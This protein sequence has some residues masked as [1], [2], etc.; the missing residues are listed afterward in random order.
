[1]N[2]NKINKIA[3]IL[4]LASGIL[5]VSVIFLSRAHL[6]FGAIFDWQFLMGFVFIVFGVYSLKANRKK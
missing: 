1:M 6:G 4:V 5:L 3:S 2:K